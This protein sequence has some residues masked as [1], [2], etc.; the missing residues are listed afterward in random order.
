MV[1][2]LVTFSGCDKW[3]DVNDDPNNP[4]SASPELVLP[5]A[6]LSVG[7][8]VGGYYNL[9]GGFWSQYWT[10]SSAANQYKYIDSYT[11]NAT[12][13]SSQWTELYA[14]ALNDLNYIANESEANEDWSMYLIATVLRAY[15]FQVLSDLYDEIPFSEAS[16]GA[17][18]NFSPIY[19]SGQ[20]VYDGLI[21]MLDNA[22][23]KDYMVN[24][25]SLTTDY[26]FGGDMDSWAKFANTLK[27]KI[28]MRQ[29]NSR[30]AIAQAGIE[31]LYND[32]AEFL[33]MDAGMDIF[34]DEKYKDNPLYAANNRNLNVATNLRASATFYL[35]LDEMNDDR[36]DYY[37]QNGSATV[38]MPQGGFNIGSTVVDP[39]TETV[40]ALY[41]TTPVNF[42][43]LAESM[44]LQAEAV[45]RGWGSGDAAALYNA[46]VAAAFAQCGLSTAGDFTGSG[47][48][49]EY[50][51]GAMADNLDA[52]YMQKWI[53]LAGTN[54][55]ES[56][57]ETNRT[58][59]PKVSSIPAWTG[60]SLNTSYLGGEFTYSLEG[61]T[62][63]GNFP[64]RL[65][66]P[67]SE[68]AANE[69]IPDALLTKTV[70]DKVWWAK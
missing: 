53:S 26:L 10:Q 20:T 49:Y 58:G 5:V 65:L 7:V 42:I 16:M 62:G 35:Y 43:S 8:V 41:P 64:K 40:F 1:L 15:S 21:T 68:R 4:S 60:S 30:P 50:P 17:D 61:V 25:K 70:T 6:S 69:N 27:L 57:F 34:I 44:F 12:D 45:A 32:G 28:Y 67:Q 46:G 24:A 31:K 56:F 54:G 52:I 18:G 36:F 22:L 9:L 13:F 47:D 48:A 59:V 63:A 14:G 39:T 23:S 2:V 51:A 11:I 33:D 38:P 29:T 19:E 37:F 55:I 3:L 66:V